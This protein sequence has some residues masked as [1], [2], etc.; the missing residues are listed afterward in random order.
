MDSVYCMFFGWLVGFV[1]GD[2][3]LAFSCEN[4]WRLKPQPT[5]FWLRIEFILSPFERD[6]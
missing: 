4:F 1:G 6:V 2:E 5:H 3:L